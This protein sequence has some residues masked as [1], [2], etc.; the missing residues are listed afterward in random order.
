ML[1]NRD[2]PADGLRERT[3]RRG[4]TNDV[5][6]R[7]CIVI[8]SRPEAIKLAPVIMELRRDPAAFE[9]SVCSTGQQRHMAP[10][11]LAE[12]ALSADFDLAVMQEN[13]TLATLTARLTE[14]LDERFASENPDCVLVQGDT[15]SAMV[16]ALTAF[17][18][19][20]PVGHVEA[21]MRTG[22]QFS[23]FP[24][25]VNR[26]VITQCA[27]LHFAPTTQCREALLQEGV[28]A[29]RVFLTGN[30]VVDALNW[31]RARLDR[32]G[33]ILPRELLDRIAGHRLILVTSHRR[34]NFGSGLRNLC[35]ALR[36]IASEFP[37]VLILY[38]V[39]PN[40]NVS[41][42]VREMLRDVPQIALVQP[43]PY[44][45]LVEL[46]TRCCFVITD[47]GGIQEEA[48]TFGKPV[49]VARDTTERPEGVRA[50]V[51]RLVGREEV[52]IADAARELLSNPVAYAAMSGVANPYGDGSAA[53]RIATV[54]RDWRFVADG[55]AEEV[56]R[57]PGVAERAGEPA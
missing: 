23:P 15:T 1:L 37:E 50:G 8:G 40:P 52:C 22:D 43:Q 17:Y 4:E 51:A 54:L 46:L 31:T 9:V 10:Q 3:V 21:G 38:P 42:P 2:S 25:E 16:G 44:G 30:T 48:P 34:E 55:S 57:A 20:I 32:T 45:M 19:R 49:L 41:I 18:R 11:A 24:E 5:R 6:R 39:H 36:R 28:P 12:F 56:A 47:S 27:T 35:L 26:R 29:S 14:G 33:S 7:I 53:A 13:Q